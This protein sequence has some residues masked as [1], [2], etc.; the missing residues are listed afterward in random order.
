[1]RALRRE[2]ACA[3]GSGH[4][5]K[6]DDGREGEER[7]TADPNR[8]CESGANAGHTPT[9]VRERGRPIGPW[10]GLSGRSVL[11]RTR[12]TSRMPRT[13]EG[14]WGSNRSADPSVIVRGVVQREARFEPSRTFGREDSSGEQ[15]IEL[16][17][18]LEALRRSRWLIAVVVIVITS[19]ALILSL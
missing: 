4:G 18:H 8:A 10:A 16:R 9:V 17:R 1:M 15:S 19:T 14:V 12:D 13:R 7:E 11:A 5:D 3:S 2:E 6:R